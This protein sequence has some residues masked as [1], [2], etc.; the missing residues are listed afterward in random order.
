[1]LRCHSSKGNLVHPK[2]LLANAIP[3]IAPLTDLDGFY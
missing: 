1:M 3:F 2:K